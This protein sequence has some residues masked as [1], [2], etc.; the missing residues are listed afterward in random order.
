MMNGES[1]GSLFG[2]IFVAIVKYPFQ[3]SGN[4]IANVGRKIVGKPTKKF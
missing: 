4:K 3:W 2:A 1:F